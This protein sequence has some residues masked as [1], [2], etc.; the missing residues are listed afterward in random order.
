MG[1]KSDYLEKALLDHVLGAVAYVAPANV[2]IALFTTAGLSDAGVG[3]AAEPVGGGYTRLAV[4]N[5]TAQ[6]PAATGASPSRKTNANLLAW[7]AATADW[8]VV[9]EWAIMDA[10]TL[11]NILYWGSFTAAQQRAILVGDTATIA[12]GVL[13]ITED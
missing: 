5:T 8:G 9:L 10:A 6:F 12:P 1:S 3:T 4:P 13:D 7:S 11:G 2:H